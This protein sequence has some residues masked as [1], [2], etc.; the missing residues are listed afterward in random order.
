[1]MGIS[2]KTIGFKRQKPWNAS[3]RAIAATATGAAAL[4]AVVGWTQPLMAQGTVSEYAK[5]PGS[6]PTGAAPSGRAAPTGAQVQAQAVPLPTQ[7]PATPPA[8]GKAQPPAA[9]KGQAPS[10]A[11]PVGSG[12]GWQ[13][14]VQPGGGQPADARAPGDN[15]ASIQ[16]VNAYFNALKSLNGVF[17]QTE[18]DNTQKKGKFYIERPGK[19][20]FDYAN[21]SKLHIISDGEY[22]AIEDHDLGTTDRYPID[23]TPFRLLLTKEV[24]LIRDARILG[25]IE[26]DSALIVALEDKSQNAGGQIRLFFSKPDFQLKE[27]IITD[28]QGLNTKITISDAEVNKALSADLF[29]FSTDVGMPSFNR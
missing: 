10:A 27:W 9:G 6:T 17:L 24:D 16:K 2:P 26:S 11:S 22:L 15:S 1:M 3:I 14:N 12:S 18:S 13:A 5:T 29:K 25:V 7:R 21:P 4:V 23:S 8:A 28:P 20:R 19:I